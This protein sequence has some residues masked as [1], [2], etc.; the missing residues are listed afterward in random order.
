[1]NTIQLILAIV[2]FIS[3]L[4]AVIAGAWLNQRAVERQM[5]SMRSEF[6]S[7]RQEIKAELRA[8]IAPLRAEMHALNEKVDRIDRIFQQLY[9]PVVSEQ[10]D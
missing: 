5:E 8:E 1:M 10:G 9:R 6:A 7:F 3:L 2:G 4:A